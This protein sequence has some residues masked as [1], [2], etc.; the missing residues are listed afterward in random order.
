[1]YR[2]QAPLE[3]P[4]IWDT[5]STRDFARKFW[6]SQSRLLDDMQE[7]ASGWFDRRHLG[8]QA[9]LEAVQKA[10]EAKSPADA[11]ACYQQWAVGA[12]LRILDD[13]FAYQQLVHTTMSSATPA[14]PERPEDMSAP[15]H[16][17]KAA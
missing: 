8:T 13:Q 11:F 1:M 5:D 2:A 15:F 6:E 9:A 12:A 17:L 4:T 7:F 10:C 3:M 14:Q 16:E